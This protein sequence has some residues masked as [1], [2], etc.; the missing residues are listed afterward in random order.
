MKAILFSCESGGFFDKKLTRRLL[1]EMFCFHL[2]SKVDRLR[3]QWQ[4]RQ[5]QQ[6]QKFL[7]V[8]SCFAVCLYRYTVCN[9]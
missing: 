6:K 3:Q 7:H 2:L 5:Q 9:A 8:F 4:Q 1:A